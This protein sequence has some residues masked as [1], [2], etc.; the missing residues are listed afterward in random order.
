[1]TNIFAGHRGYNIVSPENTMSAF[2]NAIA[3]RITAFELD[4][5]QSS[6]NVLYVMHDDTVDR[7]TN[8]TGNC[9]DLAWADIEAL[10]V[11]I[12]TGGEKVPKLETV[13]DY[14]KNRPVFILVEIKTDSNYT[15]IATNVASMIVQKK[16]QNQCI[17]ISFG[18]TQLAAVKTVDPQI[19]TWYV[20]GGDSTVAIASVVAGGHNGIDWLYT[21]LTQARIDAIHNAGLEVGCW[22]VNSATD[23]Q[24][25]I[26]LGVDSITGDYCDRLKTA[27]DNNS[28]IQAEPIK[29]IKRLLPATKT[30]DGSAWVEGKLVENGNYIDT[31]YYDRF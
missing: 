2:K 31:W 1:M 8:G 16:M 5:V 27:V 20:G 25:M 9:Y 19:K 21:D 13:L 18:L 3:Q 7:T 4:V 14:F 28:I 15:N 11:D 24:S 29:G 26:D 6:D 22:S 12:G 17:V 30:W 23:I 10:T